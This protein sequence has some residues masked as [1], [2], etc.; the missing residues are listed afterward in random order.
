[1]LNR[2]SES[3]CEVEGDYIDQDEE[4]GEDA[5]RC[6]TRATNEVETISI[7]SVGEVGLIIYKLMANMFFISWQL[8]SSKHLSSSSLSINKDT[9]P[10]ES[11]VLELFGITEPSK[12]IIQYTHTQLVNSVFRGDIS[13]SCAIFV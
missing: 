10:C 3:L 1:M 11:I 7:T 8:Q 12:A 4:G 6:D 2:I 13:I 5:T 9:K